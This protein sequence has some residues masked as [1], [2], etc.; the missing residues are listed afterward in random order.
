MSQLII[1]SHLRSA[2]LG[3]STS[4][5]LVRSIVDGVAGAT[6]FY[7]H[8]LTRMQNAQSCHGSPPGIIVSA[9]EMV[10]QIDVLT[11]L[12]DVYNPFL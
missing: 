8:A 4:A 1:T 3:M 5:F 7:F 11:K 6:E 2:S 9:M 12:G 10:I